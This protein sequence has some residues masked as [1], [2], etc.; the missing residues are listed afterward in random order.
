MH[1]FEP[2][3]ILAFLS[4][5]FSVA[6]AI[7]L[8]VRDAPVTPGTKATEVRPNRYRLARSWY[9]CPCVMK[10]DGMDIVFKNY[11]HQACTRVRTIHLQLLS[12]VLQYYQDN[13]EDQVWTAVPTPHSFIV[14]RDC[15]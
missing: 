15:Y 14:F 8:S 13:N 10:S 12:C 1:F 9:L 7:P 6:T 3:Q 2:I 5:V 11:K 4:L